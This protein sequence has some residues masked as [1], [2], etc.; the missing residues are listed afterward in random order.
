MR[1][2]SPKVFERYCTIAHIQDIEAEK[3]RLSKLGGGKLSVPEVVADVAANDCCLYP[4]DIQNDFAATVATYQALHLRL[5]EFSIDKQIS[6]HYTLNRFYAGF[7]TNWQKYFSKTEADVLY[8]LST[9]FDFSH[10]MFEPGRIPVLVKAWDALCHVSINDARDNAYR[11]SILGFRTRVDAAH[12]LAIEIAEFSAAFRSALVNKFDN[13]AEHV[14][15]YFV[16]TALMHDKRFVLIVDS[17]IS[18][19]MQGNS[20]VI[21]Q[22]LF[23]V[24]RYISLTSARNSCVK[25]LDAIELSS[26]THNAVTLLRTGDDVII[27]FGQYK[28]EL[29]ED[30][31]FDCLWFLFMFDIIHGS[32][33]SDAETIANDVL[34][35]TAENKGM[36]CTINGVTVRGINVPQ[37][38]SLVAYTGRGDD[39]HVAAKTRQS[40][41]LIEADLLR[42]MVAMSDV[43][44]TVYEKL[45]GDIP[46]E[47]IDAVLKVLRELGV[48]V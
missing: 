16:Q 36:P 34:K 17:C 11:P 25:F 4:V 24:S 12:L 21:E 32:I 38:E 30:T 40:R 35:A 20:D 9:E 31:L 28:R 39:M 42:E 45:D 8:T 18:S 15:L 47:H 5:A 22:H 3:M 2:I 6:F 48:E 26:I 41:A 27:K 7:Y 44:K 1:I 37:A 46:V 43:S 23:A 29:N 33:D 19:M 14:W 13:D 10:T